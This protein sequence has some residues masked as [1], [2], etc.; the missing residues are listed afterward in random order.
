MGNILFLFPFLKTSMNRS[1]PPSS[2]ILSLNFGHIYHYRVQ[3]ELVNTIY[4]STVKMYRTGL[5]SFQFQ[6]RFEVLVVATMRRA[7]IW[8]KKKKKERKGK[9]QPI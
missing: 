2:P 1:N 8:Y 9:S 3:H 4:H 6:M 7:I 5:M